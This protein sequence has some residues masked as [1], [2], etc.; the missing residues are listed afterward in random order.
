MYAQWSSQAVPL[1]VLCESIQRLIARMRHWLS[2]SEWASSMH[3]LP[4]ENRTVRLEGM[5]PLEDLRLFTEPDKRAVF[6]DITVEH[7]SAWVARP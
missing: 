2:G 1:R 5:L 7:G 4:P 6:N 3:W